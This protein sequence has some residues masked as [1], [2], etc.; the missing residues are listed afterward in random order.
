ML[1]ARRDRRDLPPLEV[2]VLGAIRDERHARLGGG[3][4]VHPRVTDDDGVADVAEVRGDDP[5]AIGVGFHL[6]HVV[7]GDDQVQVGLKREAL[8]REQRHLARVVG[9][10]SGREPRRP[11]AGECLERAGLQPRRFDGA[12][13]VVQGDLPHRRRHRRRLGGAV[14]DQLADAIA[15]GPCR[16]RSA[17]VL[18]ERPHLQRHRRQV[19][20]RVDQRVI[21]VED[22]QTHAV[23]VP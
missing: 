3:H 15:F 6:A 21:E 13:L 7:A 4:A 16:Q 12:P 22:A 5:V 18:D 11:R 17:V 19:E 14:T 23:T 2:S 8:E 9:P 10:H 20:R 1:A